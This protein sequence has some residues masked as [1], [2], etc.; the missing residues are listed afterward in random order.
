MLHPQIQQ[1]GQLDLR[2][3]TPTLLGIASPMKLLL[4]GV[5]K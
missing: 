5:P 2:P 3:V 4:T 1:V